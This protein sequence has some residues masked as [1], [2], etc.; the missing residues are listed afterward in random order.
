MKSAYALFLLCAATAIALPGQTFTTLHSFEGSDGDMPLAGLIQATDGNL[1][2]TTENGGANGEGTVF[3][4]TRSGTLTTLYSFCSPQIH[5]T[6]G[7]FPVAG[8]VQATDGNLYGT[9]QGP[10]GT[11]PYGTVFKITLTGTLTTLHYFCS[12]T[13]CT[14][15]VY[16]AAPLIQATDGNLY[17]TTAGGGANATGCEGFGCG[18]VFKITPGGT[19]TT[20]Y[21]FCSQSACTDGGVPYAGLVQATNGNFYGT[22]GSGGA[23]AGG[24]VFKIT[25]SGTLTTL[26]TFCSQT[27]CTDGASPQAGLV[28]ATDGNLYGTTAGGGAN[29]TACGIYDC[30]TVFKITPGGALTTLY[31][32]CSQSACSDGDNPV[33]ALIQATDGI[34]Y[35]TTSEGGANSCFL[36]QTDVGCGTVFKITPGGTLTTLYSFC[37]QGGSSC[38]DGANPYAGLVQ[39]TNGNLYGTT[40]HGGANGAG[41]VFSLPLPLP[42]VVSLSPTSLTFPAQQ[43]GTS[44]SAQSVTLRVCDFF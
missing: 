36:V 38:T 30:G 24:T 32:F 12:Q 15:G 21:S 14:D 1:Y 7:L 6:D 39:D 43:V 23:H 34:F 22:T 3:K 4:I 2:G 26:Y 11:S 42:L 8:L 16:P 17:G 35:G 27:D 5:C 44:S 25:S 31:S 29:A 18:T 40:D 10:V 13:D 9:T 19:L 33:A 37:S 20:L 41:T 28:Q